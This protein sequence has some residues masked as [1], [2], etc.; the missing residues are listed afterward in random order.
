MKKI[1]INKQSLKKKKKKV[2]NRIKKKIKNLKIKRLEL[3]ASCLQIIIWLK[4]KKS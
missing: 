2:K 4:I 3:V 1:R